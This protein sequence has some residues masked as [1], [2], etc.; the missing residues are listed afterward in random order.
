MLVRFSCGCPWITA[1]K[2]Q[3]CGCGCG[4]LVDIQ[5]RKLAVVVLTMIPKTTVLPQPRSKCILSSVS[6]RAFG[7]CT[8]RS[9]LLYMVA[10]FSIE[11]SVQ[12]CSSPRT[13]WRVYTTCSCIFIAS[14]RYPIWMQQLPRL[15]IV[16]SV[17]MCS[18]PSSLFRRYRT[19]RFCDNMYWPIDGDKAAA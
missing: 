13:L 15:L 7:Y 10:R 17:S 16:V 3:I 8:A 5:Y 9:N 14:L 11:T 2:P 18:S 1:V 12:R 19:P 4:F 6:R